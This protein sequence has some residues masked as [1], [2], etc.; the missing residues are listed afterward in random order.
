MTK[1]LNAKYA[2]VA[3]TWNEECVGAKDDKEGQS[4]LVKSLWNPEVPR[5]RAQREYLA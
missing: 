3:I 2:R 1:T 4:V 5:E